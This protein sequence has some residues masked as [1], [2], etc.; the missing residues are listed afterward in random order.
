MGM[1][2]A[3]LLLLPL[4]CTVSPSGPE[5]EIPFAL[6][7]TDE[8]QSPFGPPCTYPPITGPGGTFRSGGLLDLDPTVNPT[9]GYLLA[10][11]VVNL[12]QGCGSGCG[13]NGNTV[14]SQID[15]FQI[16]QAI[17]TYVAQQSYLAT[18][19][20]PQ[21]TVSTSGRVQPGGLDSAIAVIVQTMSSDFLSTLTQNLAAQGP[22]ASGDLILEIQLEGTLTSNGEP[23]ASNVLN[24][25]LH[26]CF[27]CGV[28]PASCVG[29]FTASPIGHGPCC[30]PQ[31]FFDLCVPCGGIGEPCCAPA[32]GGTMT[33]A[34]DSDCSSL[35]GASSTCDAGY[36]LPGCNADLS[37]KQMVCTPSSEPLGVEDCSYPNSLAL[38]Y[39]CASP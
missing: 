30:A 39:A 4:A 14:S 16:S 2:V 24:F 10:L 12:L 25:P 31:D 6:L 11:Q 18:N 21:A 20:P 7:S 15:N 32:A 34:Q 36:C 29:G 37:G 17:I 1:R 9:P 23:M 19:L 5:I 13:E 22:G 38:T 8:T 3:G 35:F 28:A 27:D 26:V 33:C